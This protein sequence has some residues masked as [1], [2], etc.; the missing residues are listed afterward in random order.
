MHLYQIWSGLAR[1]L[2]TSHSVNMYRACSLIPK[3]HKRQRKGQPCWCTK[4]L[5]ILIIK[6]ILIL[7]YSVVKSTPTYGGHDVT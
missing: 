7:K 5:V 2:R 4:Q 3:G 1:D 6:I